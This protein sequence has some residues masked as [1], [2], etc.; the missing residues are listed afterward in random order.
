MQSCFFVTG[1]F[2]T[3]GIKGEY[4]TTVQKLSLKTPLQEELSHLVNAV[5]QELNKQEVSLPTGKAKIKKNRP[6]IPAGVDGGKQG[7]GFRT[8]VKSIDCTV[9]NKEN[10]LA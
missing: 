4:E 9:K 10:E 3:W 2:Y 5:E 1:A 6:I 7:C 8:H